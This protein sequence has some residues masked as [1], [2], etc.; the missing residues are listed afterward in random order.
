MTQGYSTDNYTKWAE[1]Y[2]RGGHGKKKINPFIFGSV[3]VRF[4]APL[5]PPQTLGGVPG[6]EVKV[7][8][9]IY[10]PRIGKPKYS[11]E[12]DNGSKENGL[13]VL[14]NKRFPGVPSVENSFTERIFI[15]WKDSIIRECSPL[16]K[17]SES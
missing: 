9:D 2:I 4:M 3:T 14:K 6:S 12:K 8:A 10:P 17:E 15:P 11:R 7:P 1:E 5:H 16:M 13:P